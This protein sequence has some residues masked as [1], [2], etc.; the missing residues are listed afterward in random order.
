M[1]SG[2]YN[3][4]DEGRMM[5]A[6]NEPDEPS[7]PTEPSEPTTPSEPVDP[8]LKNGI[9]KEDGTL[10]Y[11]VNGVK[12]YAG[13]IRIDGDYYYVNGKCIVVTGRYYV[14]KNNGLMESGNYNF[15]E[16]GRMITEDQPT[17]PELKNGIINE[18]G[19]LYYYVNGVKTYAGLIKIDGYYYYINGKC[20]AVTGTYYVTKNNGLMPSAN[21]Q[22]DANG[23]MILK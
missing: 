14:T 10:Y 23:R 6:G 20:I 15:D 9:I 17:N 7:T 3:F 18:G 4:D 21:Y 5:I 19:T 22:F 1:E 13:L 11:Y 16:E 8:D 2:Y 12:T